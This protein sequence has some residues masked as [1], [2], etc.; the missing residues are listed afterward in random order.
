MLYL[1]GSGSYKNDRKILKV[2][3]TDDMKTR[4]TQYKLHNPLGEF[5]GERPGTE[6]T[7]L[8]LHLRLQDYKV[9]FLDEWFY[10]EPDVH[11]IFS[12]SEEKI[13]SWLWEH[14]SEIFFPLPK[15]GS[16][17][18]KIYDELYGIYI[19]GNTVYGEKCL[20]LIYRK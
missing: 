3:F 8:K 4:E 2:G 12:E 1:F 19:G 6:I 5:L 11:K 17:K 13:N 20:C 16:L 15:S 14:R 9:E 7:E 18:R 10:D